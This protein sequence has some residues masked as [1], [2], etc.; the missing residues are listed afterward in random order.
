MRIPV[1]SYK[2]MNVAILTL[3][4]N[5]NYGGILQAY[6]LQHTMQ[7]LGHEVVVLNRQPAFP[8]A[9]VIFIRSLSWMKCI[10]RKY[11]LGNKNINLSPPWNTFYTI[12]ASWT[13]DDRALRGFVRDEIVRTR[14]LRSSAAMRRYVKTH[15]IGAVV[16]GSD[17][18]WREAYTP[19]ITD[20]FLGFLPLNSRV[21]RIAYAASFG[22]ESEPISAA[23]LPQCVDLARKFDFISVRE[24]AGLRLMHD[25]FG[26]DA[27]LV[28]DPTLLLPAEAYRA[29]IRKEDVRPSGLVSYVLDESDEKQRMIATLKSETGLSHTELLLFPFRCRCA[30]PRC[31]SISKWL[32][33]LAEA[34]FIVTDSFHGCVFSI[35]FRKRFVAV[36]NQRRGLSRFLTLLH[37]FGLEYRLVLSYEE[38]EQKR[39]AL[40]MAPDY[41][42]VHSRLAERREECL[43][44]LRGQL[45]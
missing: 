11:I 22:T 3:G 36:G 15:G 21:G 31:V 13:Y 8:P 39:E 35:L 24:E 20:F 5:N 45:S 28:L 6:A 2:K 40:M 38:F 34:D 17:Q 14:P 19:C 43:Q 29:L 30:D 4:L 7:D 42:N 12:D 9:N 23:Q 16:V 44:W 1:S 27:H 33:A 26:L 25:V 18:V 41:E 10:V 37:T 32:S